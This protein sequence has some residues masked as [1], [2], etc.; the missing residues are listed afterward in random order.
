[1]TEQPFGLIYEGEW[2][3]VVCVDYPLTPAKYVAESFGPLIGSQVDTLFYNLCS[4]DAYCCELENGELLMDAFDKLD[5][6]WAWRYRENVRQVAAAGGNPPQ[7]ACDYGHR[8]GLKVIPVIRMNDGHDQYGFANQEVSRFKLAN[9]Q[10]LLGYPGYIDFD[11]CVA[12]HPDQGSPACFTWGLFDYAHQ[13]VR[14]H[15]FAIIEEFVTRWDNDGLSLDFDRDPYCFKEEG[16]AENAAMMTGFI[17]RIRTLL[18]E[19]AKKRGRPQYLHVRLIPEI[20]ACYQRGFDVRTWVD[21]GLVDAVSPGCGYMTFSLDLAPWLDLVAGKPCWVYPCMNKWDQP[22]TVRAWAKL[23]YR[24]GAHGLYF[25]NWGHLLYGFDKDT[26]VKT[27]THAGGGVGSPPLGSV[28]FHEA[29]PSYYESLRELGDARAIAHR[30]AVYELESLTHDVKSGEDGASYRK[31]RAIDAI[32][33]PIS[34]GVGRHSFSLPFAEDLEAA[35]GLGL[36]PRLTL[37]LK[38]QQYTEP[39]EFDVYVNGALLYP[40]TRTARAHFIMDN[41]TTFHYPATVAPWKSDRNEIAVEVRKLNPQM[42]VEPVLKNAALIVEYTPPDN[43]PG[44]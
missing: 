26:P 4:S 34:L 31:A 30:S 12:G 36:R 11:K 7:L 33:L 24:R 41:D 42:A 3:D 32:E 6:A 38:L 28:W 35:A 22:E 2:N 15:K 20:E 5:N 13:E 43:A 8:L 16:K 40:A 21:E 9:P 44:A 23:M 37:R 17:R 29:H 27:R 14:D 19:T 25:F 18:D 10:F 1:M 39:D